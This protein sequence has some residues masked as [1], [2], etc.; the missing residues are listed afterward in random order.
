MLGRRD[1]AQL[2]KKPFLYTLDQI[3]EILQVDQKYLKQNLLWW[4]GREIGVFNFREKMKAVNVAPEGETPEWRVSEGSLI[5]FLKAKGIKF[6][7][8]GWWL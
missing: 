3:A 5:N 2:P 8:Y 1:E 4:Q 6:N 7:D